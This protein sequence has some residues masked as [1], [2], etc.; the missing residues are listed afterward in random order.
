MPAYY[1]LIPNTPPASCPSPVKVSEFAKWMK[2]SPELEKRNNDVLSVI[3]SGVI[4]H[5]EAVTR[6]EITLKTFVLYLNKFPCKDFEIRR[7]KLLNIVS[8]TYLDSDNVEQTVDPLNYY[9]IESGD[10]S[11][12]SLDSSGAWPTDLSDREHCVRV[13]FTAGFDEDNCKIPE[14]LRVAILTHATKVYETRGDCDCENPN[15]LALAVP[16]QARL[17]YSQYKILWLEI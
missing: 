1:K 13:T 8:I 7:S 9:V 3:L 10:Y 14:D 11:R 16:S 17:I 6:R 5:T 15:D 2:L 4:R 12:I